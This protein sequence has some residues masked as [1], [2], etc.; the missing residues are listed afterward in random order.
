MDPEQ[1]TPCILCGVMTSALLPGQAT[2]RGVVCPR[3]FEGRGPSDPRL[4]PRFAL[5]AARLRKSMGR[6]TPTDPRVA[7][8]E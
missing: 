6:P 3:C 1:A 5:R 2:R 8:P 7:R 4:D